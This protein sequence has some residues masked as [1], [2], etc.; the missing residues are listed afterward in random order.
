VKGEAAAF[1]VRAQRC[2]S[3]YFSATPRMIRVKNSRI[4]RRVGQVVRVGKRRGA[5]IHDFCG[6]TRSERDHLEDL[7]IYGRII[8]KWTGLIRLRVGKSGGLL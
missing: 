1:S 7:S 5:C 6:K 8:L 2:Q 4:I 3:L